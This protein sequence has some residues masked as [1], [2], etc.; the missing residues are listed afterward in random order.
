MIKCFAGTIDFVD[1]KTGTQYALAKT[2][3]ARPVKRFVGLALPDSG[4]LYQGEP[5]PLH[6]VDFGIP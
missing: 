4:H 5:L 3:T 6:L 1:Q 2:G